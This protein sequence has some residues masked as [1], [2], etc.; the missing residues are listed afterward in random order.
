MLPSRMRTRKSEQEVAM[1]RTCGL[2]RKLGAALAGVTVVAVAPLLRAED[3]P[4][5]A[6]ARASVI[7]GD[8]AVQM[9]ADGDRLS[10]TDVARRRV[11]LYD[12]TGGKLRLA[13]VRQLDQDLTGPAAPQVP[14]KP[15]APTKDVPGQDPPGF[16]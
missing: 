9:S 12:T 13:D 7:A 16:P 15:A 8:V 2:I 1:M 4:V 11:A 14:A 5:V 10:V 6:A 3:A